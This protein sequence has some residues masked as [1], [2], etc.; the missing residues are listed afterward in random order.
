MLT[1]EEAQVTRYRQTLIHATLKDSRG[2]PLVCRVNGACQVWKTR[3][4]EF[5]LPVKY[6]LK[7]CFY[8]TPFNAE[9]WSLENER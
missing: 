5:K 1:K 6:G 8:I 3:P 2:A 7:Q 9:E 4:L